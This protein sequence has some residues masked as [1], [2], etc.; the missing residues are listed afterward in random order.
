M[1]VTSLK[2]KLSFQ[3]LMDYTLSLCLGLL[4]WD[5]RNQ[6]I[7]PRVFSFKDGTVAKKGQVSEKTSININQTLPAASKRI[8]V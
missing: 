5:L 4:P 6:E 3:V 1:M 2:T 8:L 7:E